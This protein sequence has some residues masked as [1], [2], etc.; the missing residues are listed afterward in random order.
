L[1]VSEKAAVLG[2][3]ENLPQGFREAAAVV[4]RICIRGGVMSSCCCRVYENLH[5]GLKV[6]AAA[7]GGWSEAYNIQPLWTRNRRFLTTWQLLIILKRLFDSKPYHITTHNNTSNHI[8]SHHNTSHHNT[9]QHNTSH[10]NTS[11]HPLSSHNIARKRTELYTISYLVKDSHHADLH[12]QS[13]CPPPL[14]QL[15]ETMMR[16]D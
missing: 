6:A 16:D 2:G 3:S 7:A 8:T 9:S 13:S 14:F 5:Q 10:H 15:Q 4:M 12:R 1:W 11:H